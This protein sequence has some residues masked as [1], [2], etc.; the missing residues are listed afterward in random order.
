M[1]RGPPLVGLWCRD[2]A[3]PRRDGAQLV[4]GLVAGGGGGPSRVPQPPGGHGW[5]SIEQRGPH[6]PDGQGMA[7][8]G[9]GEVDGVGV[10][11]ATLAPLHA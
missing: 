5:A 2:Y 7:C 8:A 6:S 11:T 3:R 1:D 9:G 10:A 4:C